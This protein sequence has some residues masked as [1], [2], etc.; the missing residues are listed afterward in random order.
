MVPGDLITVTTVTGNHVYQVVASTVV[1]P[2]EIWVTDQW[3][4]SW[5]TLT[6]CHPR[7]SSRERLVVTARLVGGPNARALVEGAA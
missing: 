7:F 4:G 6:T 2:D 5:L 1:R 3:Q